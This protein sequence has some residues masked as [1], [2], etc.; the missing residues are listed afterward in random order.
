[1]RI[2]KKGRGIIKC[3]RTNDNWNG[4]GSK[5]IGKVFG[6]SDEVRLLIQRSKTFYM[7]RRRR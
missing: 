5:Y 6:D 3:T 2:I 1:M 4:T 7:Y